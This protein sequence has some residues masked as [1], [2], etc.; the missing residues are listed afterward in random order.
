MF[1]ESPSRALGISFQSC[2]GLQSSRYGFE[3]GIRNEVNYSL[4]EKHFNE[5][6]ISPNEHKRILKQLRQSPFLDRQKSNKTIDNIARNSLMLCLSRIRMIAY[7]LNYMANSNN[8]YKSY[9]LRN[10]KS[11]LDAIDNNYPNR[12]DWIYSLL[13]EWL[14]F[15]PLETDDSV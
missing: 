2:F 8:E 4:S 11:R 5:L 1:L 14:C 9:F 7:I 6:T 10:V 15:S 3:P 13:K 12:S